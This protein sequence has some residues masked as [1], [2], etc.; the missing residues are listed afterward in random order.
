MPPEKRESHPSVC[1]SRRLRRLGGEQA[2]IVS[3]QIEIPDRSP[4][5]RRFF[6]LLHRLLDFF[7]HLFRGSFLLFHRSREDRI[8][9]VVL[10]FHGASRFFHVIEC[11]WL[12]RRSVR[13]DAARRSVDFH[14]RAAEGASHVK[15]RLTKI[16]FA[17]HHTAII[18]QS[19]SAR[20]KSN[21]QNVEHI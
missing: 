1:F 13:D 10:F 19:A 11:F 21:R 8:A 20:R 12:D 4:S 17:F 3:V 5:V 15:T 18:P 2:A 16:G 6:G 14:D 9:R 7:L